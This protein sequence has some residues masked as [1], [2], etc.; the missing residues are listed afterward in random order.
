[1]TESVNPEEM[2]KLVLAVAFL[3]VTVASAFRIEDIEGILI[4][5]LYIYVYIFERD[6]HGQHLKTASKFSL[7]SHD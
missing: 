7:V 6:V 1:M 3:L 5:K 2:A 4:D